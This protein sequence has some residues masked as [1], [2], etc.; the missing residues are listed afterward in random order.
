MSV[1]ELPAVEAMLETER[2]TSQIVGSLKAPPSA[3]AVLFALLRIRD[4][5]ARVTLP[6]GRV[7]LFGEGDAQPIDF[8][9]RDYKFARRVVFNGDIG[10]A[11]GLM[12]GEWESDDLP[13]LLTLLASNIERFKTLFQGSPLG[14]AINWLRH[15]SRE[16]TREG[17]RRNILAHYDLGNRFYET[18]LDRT[19]T[20][21]SARFDAKVRDLE[22]A[23][24]EKYRALAR[25]LELKPDDHVLEI[26]CG[27]GGFAE[28]AASEFGARVTGLTISDEQLIYARDRM[29]RLGLSDRVEIRRQ[30][31][32][33]VEGTFDKVAS[34]EM[35]EAVG[36]KYW[37]AYFSKIADVL[38]P[39]GKAALQIITIRDELFETYRRRADFIQHYVFPGGMLASIERLKLETAKAGLD[40]RQA[41]AFGQSYAETL[42]EWTRR[43]GAKWEEIRALG[44]DERFKRFW[45]FYLGYCEAGFRTGRTDVIQ[46][47]LAKPA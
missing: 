39:G 32:R 8:R 17:S 43:F 35:F 9:I 29:R 2:A 33:D 22:S 47:E 42:A 11:E 15:L 25:H 40:W 12:A 38:K 36:E 41:E 20:Y 3:K 46:L 37:E 24:L 6:N 34:I 1:M 31:Y 21:S 5:R 30:D 26:G 10:F 28:V 23:Q 19:M 44:F 13:A 45:L 27:W 4:G 7:L 18:W 14:K 16:N